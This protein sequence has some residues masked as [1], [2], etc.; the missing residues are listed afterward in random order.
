LERYGLSNHVSK[1]FPF[2]LSGGMA[3]RVLTATATIGA[4]DLL[5]ADEPT[6]G[7]DKSTAQETLKHLRQLADTG[8]AVVLI[9]HDLELA[10]QIADKVSV[11]CG[12]VTIEEANVSDF[13][14]AGK[15]RHPYSRALW[16]SLP[17]NHFTE[18]IT[19]PEKGPTNGGCPF[20][21]YCAQGTDSCSQDL[22]KLTPF[23]EGKVRCW[24]A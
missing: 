24:R 11:F 2:Q 13:S 21:P 7:L 9:T 4:A 6:N 17:R 10:L 12:G 18:A 15:L 20:S 5:L 1:W 16:A 19:R 23:D 14:G 8:K 22:P 3:R